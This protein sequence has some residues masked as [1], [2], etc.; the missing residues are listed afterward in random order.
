MHIFERTQPGSEAV[1][2]NHYCIAESLMDKG[3]LDGAIHHSTQ[4]KQIREQLYGSMHSKTVDSYQQLGKLLAANYSDYDGVVTPQ[5]RK[6]LMSAITCYERVF[7]F[8]KVHKEV[9]TTLGWL[10]CA[11]CC[12]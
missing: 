8:M 10:Q 1:A 3:D 12:K 5:I 2:E 7:K 4:A 9:Y 11:S 6:D